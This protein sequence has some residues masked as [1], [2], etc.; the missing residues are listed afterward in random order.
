M[1]KFYQGVNYSL[2]PKMR[3]NTRY[4]C[5]RHWMLAQHSQPAA[6]RQTGRGVLSE[7]DT[8]V[9]TKHNGSLFWLA[10]EWGL[11]ECCAAIGCFVLLWYPPPHHSPP[12]ILNNYIY[13]T[14]LIFTFCTS[15][16]VCVLQLWS[17]IANFTVTFRGSLFFMFYNFCDGI[18]KTCHLMVKK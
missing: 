5:E 10:L 4:T 13:Q 3:L 6:L 9:V 18:V 16:R 8:Q 11:T 1:I 2:E 12:S 17:Q 7:G 15:W 14:M